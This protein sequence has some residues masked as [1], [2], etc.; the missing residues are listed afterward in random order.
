M[1]ELF[2]GPEGFIR[3]V[4][5]YISYVS[6]PRGHVIDILRRLESLPKLRSLE[7]NDKIRN[8]F[9]ELVSLGQELRASF[10][11]PNQQIISYIGP[12]P[13][14]YQVFAAFINFLLQ[15]VEAILNQVHEDFV[16]CVKGSIQNLRTELG[17]LI[18]FLGDTAMH[19]QPTKNILIDMA[20][21]VNE[22]GN[23]FYSFFLAI[24]VFILILEETT[25][26]SMTDIEV[27]VNEVRSLLH[28]DFFAFL[29]NIRLQTTEQMEETKNALTDI[30]PLVHEVGSFLDFFIF[31]GN[32]QVPE[33]G[34]LDLALSDLL[35]KFEL[36]KAKINKHCFTVSKMPSDMAPNTAVVSLFIFYSV[37]DDLMDL[38]NNNSERIVGVDDQIVTLHEEL[39]LLGSTLIDIAVHEELLIRSRDI[40]Y[41]VEYVINSFPPVWYLTLQLPQLIEKIQLIRMSIQEIKNK[42]DVA[43]VPEVPKYPVG[44]ESSQSK[45]PPIKEDIVVGFDN[46]A[47]K[48]ADQLVRGTE[49]LQIISIFGMP[50]L[51]KTTLANK[52]YNSLSVVNHFYTRARCDV[53]QRY[54]K[55]DIL[56]AILSSLKN[57]KKEKIVNTDDEILAEDLYKSLKGRRYLIVF[58]DVWDMKLWDDL[59]WYFPNDGIGSRILF[60]TRNKEVGLKASPNSVPNALPFLS[61]EECWE[62]LQRKVFQDEDCPHKYLDIGKQIAKN[63]HGLPLAVVVIAGVLA[64]MDKKE[65]SWEKV[66]R[67]LRSHISK[68]QIL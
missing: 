6:S 59:K 3:I 22:V 38:I 20:A 12:T 46:V 64:N 41:E 25:Y 40:A 11:I 14:P 27:V 36:L 35:L 67:N 49:Q 29:G 7:D 68:I 24:I 37:L 51:G 28:S 60:T 5:E 34:V 65:H 9:Q 47:I 63:C 52:V 17:F 21:V 56:I 66:A 31:T 55:K 58:D 61:E 45:E 48:I 42:L 16:A 23:F 13:N 2:T 33:N 57:L 8:F 1:D 19:L 32:D 26:Y 44:Q 62:L 53:S 30:Q 15:M 18:T 4:V 10:T 54:N 39:K 50:G 43:G